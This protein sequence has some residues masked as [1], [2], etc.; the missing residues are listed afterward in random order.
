MGKIQWS[1]GVYCSG[2]LI[3]SRHVATAKHCA[4][5]NN[6]GVSVRFMPAYYDGESF[7]GAY[8]TTIIYLPDYSVN[9]PDANACDIKEDWAIFIL[10]SRL[11]DQRGGLGAK[12]IEPSIINNPSLLNLGYPGDLANGNRPYRQEKITVRNKFDCDATGG[13][14]TD[15]DVAGGMSGGPLNIVPSPKPLL[16]TYRIHHITRNKTH[17]NPKRHSGKTSTALPYSWVFSA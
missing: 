2:A 17:A 12:L 6:P 16:P 3:G 15:A 10:D 11:G 4:P 14:S 8:V 9:D 5:L 13:L 1:N 7:P